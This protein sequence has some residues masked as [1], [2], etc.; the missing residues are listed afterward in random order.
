MCLQK[1]RVLLV[2]FLSGI[3]QQ[4]FSQR[5]FEVSNQTWIGYFNQT[6]L[7]ERSGVWA[8]VH[9]RLADDFVKE[10]TI[11]IARVAYIYYLSE[12]VKLMAGYAFANRF[13]NV[14]VSSIPEHRPW[15]QIQWLQAK[16]RFVLTQ[17][18][19]IEQRFRR[20][21]TDGELTDDYNFNWRFRYNISFT[22]P[23]WSKDVQPESWFLIF[24]NDIHI[25]AG[26][27]VMHSYFDQNR[28]FLGLGYQFTSELNAH[29]G[30]LFILQQAE[31]DRYLHINAIRLFLT[32]NLDLRIKKQR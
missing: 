18:V 23:L 9:Y 13:S 6:R 8:D 4:A 28:S 26:K 12:N 32:H 30:Y 27:E 20:K 24:G 3:G 14:G 10:K 5:Q 11:A 29:L 25:N 22:V 17:S 21:V 16:K 15:Q 7:T 2:F 31:A 1:V 19:R